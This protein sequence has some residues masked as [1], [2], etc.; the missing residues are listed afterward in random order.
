MIV[1][2]MNG[3]KAKVSCKIEVLVV[4]NDKIDSTVVLPEHHRLTCYCYNIPQL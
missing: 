4:G 1:L 3:P 2:K